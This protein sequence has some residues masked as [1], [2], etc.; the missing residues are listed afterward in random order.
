M[1]PGFALVGAGLIGRRHAEAIAASGAAHLH[2][3]T[4]P[5]PEARAW[6]ESRGAPWH[7][8]LDALLSGPR[9]AAVILATPT[10]AHAEG[11]LA[12]LAAGLPVLVEKP[13]AA[14]LAAA[15]RMVAAAE[16]AGLPLAVGHHRRHNPRIAAA[17][18]MIAAGTLGQI[19][20][21]QASFW[22][23]KPNDY[24]AT[25]WRRAVGAGPIL[26]NLIHDIDL[27]RHLIGEIAEVR[28]LT[29]NPLRGHPVEETAAVLLRFANGALGT[30]SLSDTTPAPW[31]WELTARENPAYPA[32]D[33]ACYHIGGTRAS[34]ELPSLTLWRHEG[35]RG[36]WSP[37]AAC[38]TPVGLDDPLVLQ[39]RQFARVIAGTEAPLVSGREGLAT[40][41]VIDAIHRSAAKTGA[42]VRPAA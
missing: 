12:C 30:V 10:Q 41:A 32:T 33:A 4:D 29:A 19:T 40:L 8:G 5:A 20:A 22:V 34:L 15:R 1:T 36:W 26:T 3:V 38:R 14:D 16:A 17:K 25:P 42:A 27:L 9:P 7:P 35:E 23:Q 21:V 24:F 18:A 13:I 37:L 11:A 2:S 6:A 39:I 31:S 28:A